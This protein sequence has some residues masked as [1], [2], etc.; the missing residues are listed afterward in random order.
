MTSY[1]TADEH[2][3][4]RLVERPTTRKARIA[5]KKVSPE[6]RATIRRLLD[7]DLDLG[8]ADLLYRAHMA[9]NAARG[10]RARAKSLTPAR[11]RDIAK[12]A[13]RARWGRS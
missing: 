9:A 4:D 1:L 7:E 8:P 5:R 6:M 13:A 3:A 12:R 11:R 2:L 10:G